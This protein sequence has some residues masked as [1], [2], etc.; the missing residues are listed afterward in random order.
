MSQVRQAETSKTVEEIHPRLDPIQDAKQIALTMLAELLFEQ[1][2]AQGHQPVKD[3]LRSS[4]VRA[5]EPGINL[6]RPK[7]I[8]HL[9]QAI[10]FQS[11]G[12]DIACILLS[13]NVLWMSGLDNSAAY[14]DLGFL[15]SKTIN[16]RKLSKI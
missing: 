11:H 12:D 14:F 16:S 3:F 1:E 6:I 2:E 7:I 8:L 13:W 5:E 9:S 15:Q 10:D 4:K